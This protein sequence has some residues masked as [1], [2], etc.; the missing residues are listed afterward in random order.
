MLGYSQGRQMQHLQHDLPSFT[1]IV[2]SREFSFP[3]ANQEWHYIAPLT[4]RA[5]SAARHSSHT[6]HT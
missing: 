5:G 1:H 2:S 4:V 6:A 3:L